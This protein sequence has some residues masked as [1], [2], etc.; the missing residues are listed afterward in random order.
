MKAIF[1]IGILALFVWISFE[2]GY[3]FGKGD[4]LIIN[5][6]GLPKSR[7]YMCEEYPAIRDKFPEC[8]DYKK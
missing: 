7:L 6:G 2:I 5:A 3:Q 8:K 4:A 1:T